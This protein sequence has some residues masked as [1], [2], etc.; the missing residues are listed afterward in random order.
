M[1]RVRASL[2]AWYESHRRDL[3]WRRTRDPYAVW[4]SETIL[5][6]TR[7]Q[8]GLPYYLRFIERFPDVRALAAASEDEVLK[9]WQGLG[10]YSRARNLLRAARE[11]VERFGGEF[12]C[13]YD[14][15]RSLRGVGEYTAS[16]VASISS[17]EAVAVVDG[18]VYRVLARLFDVDTP[19]D[20]AAGQ[21]QFREL[22]RSLLD[23]SD[24]GRW[25]Q[26][27]MEFGALHCTPRGA[28][29]EAC[30]VQD[31]CLAHAAGTVG[32]RPA[33]RGKARPADRWFHYLHIV[34]GGH[35]LLHRRPEG[36]IWAGLYEFPLMECDRACDFGELAA[37]EPLRRLAEGCALRLE[38]VVEMPC[39]R[40][41]HRT[42]HARFFRLRADR[43]PVAEGGVSASS[44]RLSPT[45]ELVPA[46]SDRLSVAGELVPASP[47]RLSVAEG[48]IA[49]PVG[50]LDR[51]ALPRLVDRYLAKK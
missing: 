21:R 20:T 47:D 32:A 1:K 34:A 44:D 15:L 4:L 8:Q 12:P 25:N 30:P 31:R 43:L 5:Q 45:R 19:V 24:A 36:D 3:P 39:H 9:L 50:C 7:V 37:M 51:Y 16:A 14:D 28:R 26:A 40:L 6:Q 46:S 27:L 17:G 23:R 10:Y 41:T 18:N 11:V 29:C 38:G 42:I 48:L 2:C 33:K 35:T 13:R 49:V 22:A